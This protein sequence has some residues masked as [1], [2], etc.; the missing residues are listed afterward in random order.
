ME[1]VFVALLLLICSSI[2]FA[3]LESMEAINSLR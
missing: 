2:E 3:F 1:T